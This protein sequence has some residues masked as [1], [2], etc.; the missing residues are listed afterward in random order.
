MVTKILAGLVLGACATSALAAEP[1]ASSDL[2]EARVTLPYPE[3]KAL[4]QAAHPET[5]PKRK[6]PIES[7]LLSARYQLVLKGDLAA[8]AV[9]YEIENFSDEWATIPL[10]G[11]QTQLDEIEPADVQLIVRDGHYALVTNRPGKQKL[12]LKFAVKLNGASFALVGAPAAINTVSVAGLPEKQTLRIADSTQISAEKDRISFRLP[13]A[14]RIE[15]ELIPEKAVVPPTPSRWN[16]ETQAFVQFAEGKLKY[17]ARFVANADN[18]SGLAMDLEFR[19]GLEITKVAGADL[20]QWQASTAA[21]QTRR[22][23]L[24]WQTRDVLRREVEIEYNGAQSLMG[25]EWNLKAPR[26]LDGENSPPLFVVIPEPGLELTATAQNA[27]PRQLPSWMREKAEGKNYLVVL[28]DAPVTAKWLPLVETAQA[29]VETATAKTRIVSDGALLTEIDY[30]IRHERALHWTIDLPDGSELLSATI[31]GQPV[32]PIDRGERVLEFAL[33]GGKEISAVSF[34]YTAKKP[35]FKPVSGQ[36]A[37][38]L[39]QTDLLIHWLDW[40]LRIP[41]AYEIA[42]FEGNVESAPCDKTDATSRAIPLHK[43]LCKNE[44]PRAEFFYQKP[45]PNK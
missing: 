8:G 30:S 5:P 18:G 24:Q 37:V 17:S 22:L 29:V 41:V 12:R 23:H 27:T 28:G 16:L 6:P 32:K 21:D 10:L 13:A 2:N 31:D 1:S 19:P 39:P 35:A 43:E 15:L 34:S 38:E 14:E 11:A 44:R 36:I 25:A 33:P 7:A 42:A 9:D 20:G 3:L 40:E 26:L 45:Q 4:W